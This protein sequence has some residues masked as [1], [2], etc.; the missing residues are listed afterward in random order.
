MTP[1]LGHDG[2]RAQVSADMDFS[3]IEQSLESFNPDMPAIRSEQTSEDQSRGP[4]SDGGV[5]GARSN[6]PPISGA[7]AGA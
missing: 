6:Q 4:G 3:V 1:F 5:P 2:V 7:N